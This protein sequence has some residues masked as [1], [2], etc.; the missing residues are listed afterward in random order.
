MESAK[1]SDADALY[2]LQKNI[3]DLKELM[4]LTKAKAEKDHLNMDLLTYN[5]QILDELEKQEG[6]WVRDL[7][8]SRD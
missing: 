4:L 1:G 2:A 3:R 5:Q 7:M 6:L 8:E